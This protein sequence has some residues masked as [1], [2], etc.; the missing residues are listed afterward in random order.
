MPLQVLLDIEKA[1]SL[2]RVASE[3]AGTTTKELS[4]DI[5]HGNPQLLE[6]AE[7]GKPFERS[8]DVRPSLAGETNSC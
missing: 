1:G 7:P 8:T 2:V 3:S 4:K 6:R 5:D